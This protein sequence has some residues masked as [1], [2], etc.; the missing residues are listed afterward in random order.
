MHGNTNAINTNV[1]PLVKYYEVQNSEFWNSDSDFGFENDL[2]EQPSG[3][4]PY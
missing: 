2:P 3:P 1:V 4:S